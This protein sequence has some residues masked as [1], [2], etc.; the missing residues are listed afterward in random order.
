MD[1]PLVI[2]LGI[3]PLIVLSYLEEDL[4][5]EFKPLTIS[6]MFEDLPFTQRVIR[7]CLGHLLIEECIEVERVPGISN[8]YRRGPALTKLVSKAKP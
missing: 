5:D 1:M 4:T 2:R 6:K 8:Q 7:E 3:K